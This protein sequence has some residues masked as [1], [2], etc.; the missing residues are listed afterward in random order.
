MA[1]DDGRTK[2][3]DGRPKPVRP[4]E[5]R[6]NERATSDGLTYFYLDQNL[7]RRRRPKDVRIRKDGRGIEGRLA[8]R[9]VT[10]SCYRDIFFY[11]HA[12]RRRLRRLEM[13][14]RSRCG[15]KVGR[16]LL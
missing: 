13:E 4:I 11:Y 9:A 12:R 1:S 3:T 5:T 10:Q 7:F 15:Q 2:R 16:A 6:K 8:S 14:Q